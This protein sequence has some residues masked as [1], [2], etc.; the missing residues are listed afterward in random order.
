MQQPE[1]GDSEAV[2]HDRPDETVAAILTGPEPVAVLYSCSPAGYLARPVA[3]AVF[4]AD[5][6][7]QNLAAPAIVVSG[8][9]ENRHP[10]VV[11]LR[12]RGERPE[13]PA[14]NHGLPLEPEIEEVAVDDERRRPAFETAEKTHERPLRLGR[15]DTQVRIGNHVTRGGQHATS[16]A[17]EGIFTKHGSPG[18]FA[19]PKGMTTITEFRVRYAET[20]QMGVVYHANYLIWCEIGRTDFIR[21]LGTPYAE[22][23]RQNVALAVVDASLR[24]HAAAH[25]DDRI[26]VRTSLREAGSRLITFD[27]LIENADSNARMVSAST[28]LASLTRDSKPTTLPSELRARLQNAIA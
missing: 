23:E 16:L 3:D 15:S 11:Q 13:A 18:I 12:E 20:D 5:V 2:P 4:R 1:G 6:L 17:P 10:G 27:Y 7:T 8:D 22:L 9:P 19:H 25:Y 26:R 24:F 28:T 21:E 14:G